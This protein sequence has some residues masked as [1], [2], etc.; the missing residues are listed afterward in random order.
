LKLFDRIYLSTSSMLK[1]ISG[2]KA[3][4]EREMESNVERMGKMGN[5]TQH[6]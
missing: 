5:S 3:M 4:K 6:F 2:N 1:S